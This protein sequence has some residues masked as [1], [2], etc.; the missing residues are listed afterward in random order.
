MDPH[1]Y[2]LD[3]RPDGTVAPGLG[4]LVAFVPTVDGHSPVVAM[5][6]DPRHDPGRKI[7]ELAPAVIGW[8]AIQ[9]PG[10]LKDACW[11]VIDNY[12]RF[13]EVVPD[14]A[15][16]GADGM[17][18]PEWGTAGATPAVE[19]KRFSSGISIDAF[20]QDAG[21]A[22]EAAIELLSAV[23]E[24]PH[25]DPATPSMN[26]FLDAVE[27]HGSLPAP[28]VIFQKVAIAAEE[29][30]AREIANAIQP[31]PVISSSLINSANAA[32]FAGGGKTASV[33]QA[34]TRLGSVFVKRVVFVAEMMARYQKGACPGF[35]YRG[36][37]YNAI[38]TGAAMRALLPA[39]DIPERRAD[40][41][42]TTGLVSGIGWLA[43]AETYPA[44]MQRY[45]EHKDSDPITK[46][47]VQREIFPCEICKVSER[48]LQRFEFPE[49]V[50]AA[51][52][53]R[54]DVDRQWYD[55]LARAIRVAQGMSPFACLAIPTTIPVPEACREEWQ[56]WKGF[57]AAH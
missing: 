45:L 3:V 4:V 30:D 34:V 20:Y 12:G 25:L 11:T 19:F 40:E 9:L 43:V 38:A 46:A 36:F 29:G 6:C 18:C 52:A 57:L 56:R 24:G 41:A 17:K 26:E 50:S 53:G 49:I 54:T 51:V 14:F 33:P 1:T 39:Y 13:N 42:F 48:Y 31:D 44:L 22:G 27:A 35:D 5:A 37:W 32:R 8:L 10:A 28:G 47:R 15:K 21:P 55:V 2:E 16:A 7:S 23:I